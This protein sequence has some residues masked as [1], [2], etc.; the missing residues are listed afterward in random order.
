[1]TDD[2][3]D[4]FDVFGPSEHGKPGDFDEVMALIRHYVDTHDLPQSEAIDIILDIIRPGGSDNSHDVRP[5]FVGAMWATGFGYL[6][7]KIESLY[8]NSMP[9]GVAFSI[10]TEKG[11]RFQRLAKLEQEGIIRCLC[12]VLQAGGL[13]ARVNAENHIILTDDEGTESTM[14]IDAM[15]SQFRVEIDDALGPDKPDDPMRR[16]MP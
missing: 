2:N 11:F 14:D 15:V 8:I 6:C 3:E 16:W 13:K 9:W 12:A 4:D 1:M 7:D 10:A 5:M